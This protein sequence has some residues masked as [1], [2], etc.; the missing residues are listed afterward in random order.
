VWRASSELNGCAEMVER[1]W[2]NGDDD[3]ATSL[4][5]S[6]SGA[7]EIRRMRARATLG[8]RAPLAKL[9]APF[10]GYHR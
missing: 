8:L 7:G 3:S 9:P 1:S 4:G 6:P 10:G 5:P 2:L